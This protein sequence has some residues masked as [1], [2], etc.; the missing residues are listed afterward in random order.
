MIFLFANPT[1]V[2]KCDENCPQVDITMILITMGLT[3]LWFGFF[4]DVHKTKLTSK[5]TFVLEKSSTKKKHKFY[6]ISIFTQGLR[7][8]LTSLSGHEHKKEEGNN[9]AVVE[10]VKDREKKTCYKCNWISD[11]TGV[12]K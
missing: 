5:L 10:S 2:M 3:S 4:S 11:I 1:V 6:L 9:S 7:M 12:R 8:R